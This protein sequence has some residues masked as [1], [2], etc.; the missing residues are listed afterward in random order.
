MPYTLTEISSARP[1]LA[2]FGRHRFEF[3]EIQLS[4]NG[5]LNLYVLVSNDTDT[6]IVF[7][8]MVSNADAIVTH[9]F[10]YN[11]AFVT[12]EVT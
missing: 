3:N 7:E 4:H 10:Y 2:Y 1:D 5:I 8:N 11:K 6:D 12:A 9:T